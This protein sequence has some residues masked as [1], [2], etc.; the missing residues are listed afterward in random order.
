MK[1]FVSILTDEFAE[2]VLAVVAPIQLHT[3]GHRLIQTLSGPRHSFVR[4]TAG[5]PIEQR[6]AAYDTAEEAVAAAH[7]IAILN[8]LQMEN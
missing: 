7:R 1:H 3:D 5:D 4:R 2:N 6:Y 8:G